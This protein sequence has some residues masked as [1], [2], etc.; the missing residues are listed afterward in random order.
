MVDEY[1]IFSSRERVE[2]MSQHRHVPLLQLAWCFCLGSC[3]F[4][5]PSCAGRLDVIMRVRKMIDASL[6]YLREMW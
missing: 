2:K 5:V 6:S 3:S 1:D 4:P